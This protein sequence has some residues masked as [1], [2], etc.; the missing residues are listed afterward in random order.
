MRKSFLIPILVLLASPTLAVE[1]LSSGTLLEQCS[2]SDY[3]RRQACR[4]WIHGFMGGA[5]AS[6]TAKLT[7]AEKKETFS[8]RAARTRIS[9]GRAMFG[10]NHDAGYCVPKE[11]TL[12]ELVEKLAAHAGTLKEIPEHANQL[13]LGL[14]R[15]HYPCAKKPA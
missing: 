9:R 1:P 5:F 3:V 12:D 8:E 6:R 10:Q 13:M 7:D 2:S 11:T 4:S 14:L 15:K